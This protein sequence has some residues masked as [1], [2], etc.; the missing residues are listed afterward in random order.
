[1]ASSTVNIPEVFLGEV[2][3]DMEEPLFAAQRLQFPLQIAIL[4]NE[5]AATC[6]AWDPHVDAELEDWTFGLGSFDE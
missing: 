4:L 2:E 3:V 1:M 5:C 6:G